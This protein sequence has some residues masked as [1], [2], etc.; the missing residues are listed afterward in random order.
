MKSI[1]E[2]YL[3][4]KVVLIPIKAEEKDEF[5][6]LATETE[7]SKFWYGEKGRAQFRK[8]R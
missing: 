8:N 1:F 3:G 5:Y 6:K 2:K 4:E 7:G